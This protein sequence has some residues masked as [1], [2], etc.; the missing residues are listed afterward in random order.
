LKPR[1]TIVGTIL[2]ALGLLTAA[3]GKQLH[4]QLPGQLPGQPTPY[5]SSDSAQVTLGKSTVALNGPWKFQVGDSPTDP[6]TGKPLWS[7]PNFDD[8]RWEKVDLSSGQGL[9]D[10][11]NGMSGYAPGWTQRGHPGYWGYAWYR[12]HVQ[13]HTQPGE[14]LALGGPAIMDDAYQAFANGKLLGSFGDFSSTRPSAYYSQPKI[15]PLGKLNEQTGNSKELV[16]SFRVWM[17]PNSLTNQPDAGG[18]HSP[19]L[20]GDAASVSGDYQLHWL[21]LI[22]A[23][24]FR[25]VEGVFYLFLALVVGTL[26]IFDREDRVFRWIVAVFLA[27]AISH[28]FVGIA[29]WTQIFSYDVPQVI[30]DVILGPMTFAGW[31]MVW[32]TW[33]GL[34]RPSWIPTAIGSLLLLMMLSSAIEGEVFF[35]LIPHAVTAPFHLVSLVVRVVFMLLITWIVIL[36]TRRDS[37]EGFLVLPAVIMLGISRF[38]TELSLLHIRLNWFL[39]GAAISLRDVANLILVFSLAALL[40]RRLMRSVQAQRRLALD[41]KQAQEVQR[42]IL[43]EALSLF[44]GLAIESEYR[45]A[46][47]VGGD[48]FQIIPHKTDGSLMIVAGDVTGKGLRAG[49]LVALLVGAIRSTVELNSDPE[50]VLEALNR[51]LAGRSDSQA[52]CLALRIDQAGSAT[53]A[54]AGH[55]P[56]YLNGNPIDMQGA[57][58]LGM[59]HSPQFSVMRFQLSEG[60]RLILTSDGIAEATDTNG[61]L[62]GFERVQDLMRTAKTAAEIANAA[63]AFGQEDDISVISVTRTAAHQAP[64]HTPAFAHQGL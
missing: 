41:V 22:R 49:M 21:A 1:L 8:S 52:T 7:Q 51:R 16:L 19:P 45:P 48:F 46:R 58:P 24:I 30:Q 35:T 11:I 12:I 5:P 37:L 39:L 34:R 57:L 20:L 17:E 33:F 29:S 32:W 23:Y 3:P 56:P 43:P 63:Q 36:G 10:P 9:L 61:D 2:L 42:V 28:F 38:A 4:A 59:T 27:T 13:L 55:M 14:E 15:F 64:A 53:L 26:M 60:D 31:A 62:F 54:N 44:P 6:A 25:A 40:L 47:E 18:F 50:F